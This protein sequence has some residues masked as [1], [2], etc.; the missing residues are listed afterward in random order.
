M[1]LVFIQKI[2]QIDDKL[3]DY[4][5]F[6]YTDNNYELACNSLSA[7]SKNRIIFLMNNFVYNRGGNEAY[8][9]VVDWYIE[10]YNYSI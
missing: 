10:I 2:N 1:S 5:S 3:V 7:L 6:I 9:H 8:I 4:L